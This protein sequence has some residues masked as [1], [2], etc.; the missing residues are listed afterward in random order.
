MTLTSKE[1]KD[2]Y[3]L[4]RRADNYQFSKYVYAWSMREY[5]DRLKRS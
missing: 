1:L 3:D 2:L 5:L 4:M